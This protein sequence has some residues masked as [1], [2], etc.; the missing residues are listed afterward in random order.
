MMSSSYQETETE[1]AADE[2][3]PQDGVSA[4]RYP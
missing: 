3:G 4:P 1:G 2:G